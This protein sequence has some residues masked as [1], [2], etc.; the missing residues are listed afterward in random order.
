MVRGLVAVLLAAHALGA[1]AQL[2]RWTDSSGRVHYTDTPPPPSATD[3]KQ[4]SVPVSGSGPSE[5]FV[6]QQA[7]KDFPVK[8]YTAPGCQP[9]DSARELLNKRGVPFSEVSISGEP[10]KLEELQKTTG[11]SGV[12]AL[13]VGR[14]V[15]GGFED[16]IYHRMLDEGGYPKMGILSPR[17]QAEPKPISPET[18]AQPPEQ[19]ALGPYA[20]GSTR[21][22]R[23]GSQPR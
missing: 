2:Y 9:C 23:E 6:L 8:L 11:I 14:H 19:P 5:P 15:Q 17:N 16:A 1:S 4:K 12:P 21:R 7:R 22:L 18:R 3:V 13:V 20:P 10:D